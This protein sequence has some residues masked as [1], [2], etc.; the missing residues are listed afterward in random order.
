[1]NLRNLNGFLPPFQ[2]YVLADRTFHFRTPTISPFPRRDEDHPKPSHLIWS[3]RGY[4][5]CTSSS[6]TRSGR[7]RRF[8]VIRFELNYV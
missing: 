4:P 8:L 2:L 7:Q 6:P 5:T 3:F 1:M